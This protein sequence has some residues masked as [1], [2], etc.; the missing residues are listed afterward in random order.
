[1][2]EQRLTLLLAS[3]LWAQ[4]LLVSSELCFQCPFVDGEGGR[5]GGGESEAWG[6]GGR[7]GA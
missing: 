2:E 7:R 1:M 5:G 3:S 6:R 4:G